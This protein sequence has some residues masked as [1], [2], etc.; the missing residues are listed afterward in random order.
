MSCLR[1]SPKGI[2]HF[3]RSGFFGEAVWPSLAEAKV[4]PV[5]QAL[6]RTTTANLAKYPCRK[7]MPSGYPTA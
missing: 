3:R 7:T 6:A 1:F 4:A 5:A 2:S